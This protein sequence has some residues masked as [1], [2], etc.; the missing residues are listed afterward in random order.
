MAQGERAPPSPRAQVPVTV[1]CTTVP[2][3]S[4]IVTVS[5]LSFCRNLAACHTHTNT[6]TQARARE[7]QRACVSSMSSHVIAR[8]TRTVSGPIRILSLARHPP[9]AI[10]PRPAACSR[11]SPLCLADS[12]PL[13]LSSLRRAAHG[14]PVP[15]ELHL[16]AWHRLQVQHSKMAATEVDLWFER[17]QRI[18]DD[19]APPMYVETCGGRVKRGEGHEG[20]D[21]A[22]G[23]QG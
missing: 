5:L 2:F 19:L 11:A 14:L 17:L 13:S 21:L 3:L 22:S 15:N 1:P 10:H 16:R 9:S 18:L 7:S 20:R 23:G 12:P 6:H 4:S 8:T